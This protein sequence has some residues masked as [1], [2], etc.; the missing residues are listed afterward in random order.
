MS[1][2][3]IV[4]RV[5]NRI[6]PYKPGK[7]ISEVKREFKLKKVYKMASNENAL[8]PSPKALS[9]IKKSLADIHYYPD[10][11][12]FELR[13][14]ISKKF[15]LNMNNIIVG[16]GSDELI[17]LALKAF[18]NKG[19]EV[20]IAQP[21]F[22]VYQ[23]AA[24]LAEAKI[25][26][27]KQKAF[28]YDLPAIK[29]KV[30]SRTKMIFIANPDNPTGSYVTRQEVEDFLKSLP[31]D[32]IVFFDEAY[33]EFVNHVK[34]YPDTI[35][36]I[37][38]GNIIVSRSFSKAYGLGGLRAGWAVSSPEIIGY[39]NQ[40]REPFNVNMLAQIGAAAA[41][42]DSR[43][44]ARSK[45]LVEEGK[46]FLYSEFK[47]MNLFFVPSVTNFILVNVGP[48][49]PEIFKQLLHKGIIVREMSSWGIKNFI[50]VTIGQP[51]ENRLFVKHLKQSLGK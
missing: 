43:H 34:D 39:L 25:V 44:I 31:K 4:R 33:Y 47:K 27:V 41:L 1:V 16:N 29:E 10:G 30:T 20:I 5:V 13:R 24:A 26:F 17:V 19:D 40:V 15:K 45:R 9:A 3:N 8:G 12:S 38:K 50:R 18:I 28:R 7:P 22:L 32:V 42:F 46:R 6:K 48:K 37:K 14:A 11:A 23:L 35:E 51:K 49:A 2:K 36:Y 21:T